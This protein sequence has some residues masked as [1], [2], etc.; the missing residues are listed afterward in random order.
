VNLPRCRLL[1]A[2]L[3]LLP[4]GAFASQPPVPAWKLAGQ[5]MSAVYYIAADPHEVDARFR[6]VWVLQDLVRPDASG[7][8]SYRYLAEYDCGE[9]R[10][11]TLGASYFNGPL[12]TGRLTGGFDEPSVWV[13]TEP[14][15][16]GEALL[17]VVC[18]AD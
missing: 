16:A 14:G 1:I 15:S 2:A 6:Q 11:R 7:A 8:R 17:Q 10:R 5:T 13:A 3:A 9:R 18:G 12:A 4:L